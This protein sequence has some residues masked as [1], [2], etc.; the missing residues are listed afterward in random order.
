MPDDQTLILFGATGDLCG[1]HLLPAL[2]RLHVAGELPAGFRLLGTGPQPWDV[3]TFHDHVRQ[4]LGS[5]APDL[6]GDIESFLDLTSYRA[7]DVRDPAAVGDLI[8]SAS[9]EALTFYLALPTDLI[10][11]TVEGLAQRGLP[12]SARIAVEKPFGSDLAS[13]E[14]LNVALARATSDDGHVFRVDHFLG[15]PT[16]QALPEAVTRLRRESVAPGSDVTRVSVLWEETLALEGRAAF[17]DRAGALKDLLQNHLVQILCQVLLSGSGGPQGSWSDRR[18]QS[19]RAVR[20]PT[21]E[22]ARTSRRARYTAGTLLAATDGSTT[23]VPD[24]VGEKGVDASRQTETFAEVSLHVDTPQWPATEF[25]LRAGKAMGRIRQG[26]LLEFRRH[27]PGPDAG[28]VCA[29][30]T[31]R[32]P[33]PRPL[34]PRMSRTLLTRPSDRRRWNSWPMSTF[35]GT[36]C[37]EPLPCPCHG[38]KP[39]WRGGSS[40]RCCRNGPPVPCRWKHIQPEPHLRPR[41]ATARSRDRESRRSRA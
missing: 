3:P 41:P 2:V 38:K 4:R 17:Y 37:R 11:A 28:Q 19:L 15:M 33:L 21:V 26:L 18:L 14:Q 16:V 5:F 39:S 40:P 25:V 34:P 12:A 32:Q 22:Q 24:Y 10:A 20:I 8:G 29:V 27:S 23:E 36:C 31:S 9:G 7:V 35:F 6:A 1:R 30:S 13:A